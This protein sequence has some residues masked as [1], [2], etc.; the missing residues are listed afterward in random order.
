MQKL[1]AESYRVKVEMIS[2]R[3]LFFEDDDF[4]NDHNTF[5]KYLILRRPVEGENSSA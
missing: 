1:I 5:P 4:K 2:E 3:E